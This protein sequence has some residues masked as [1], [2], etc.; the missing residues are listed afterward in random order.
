M[1]LLCF[2]E[3]LSHSVGVEALGPLY[4]HVHVPKLIRL[5]LDPSGLAQ[6]RPEGAH[7]SFEHATSP[8]T[9]AHL[10][11]PAGF[12]LNR[13]RGPGQLGRRLGAMNLLSLKYLLFMVGLHGLLA[14]DTWDF[15]VIGEPIVHL[16]RAPAQRVCR[17]FGNRSPMRSNPHMMLSPSACACSVQGRA[18]GG[19]PWLAR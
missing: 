9:A 6:P 13:F 14:T 3:E 8:G 4:P 17:P 19:R 11:S 15:I 1:L 5:V 2:A 16:K 7:T 12:R 10:T 18:P